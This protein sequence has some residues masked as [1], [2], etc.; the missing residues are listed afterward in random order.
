VR[1]PL[2][3]SGQKGPAILAGGFA[4]LLAFV[5]LWAWLSERQ[6][7]QDTL[8]REAV[9]TQEQ[10][11]SVLSLLQDAETGQRG[12]LITADENYLGPY[13]N[14]IKHLDSNL[15]L[16]SQSLAG[17]AS[18]SKRFEELRPIVGE[19][20]GALQE[21]IT[22]HRQR[23]T[24]E[25]YSLIREGRGQRLMDDIRQRVRDLQ[26]AQDN[27]IAFHTNE[28]EVLREFV[29]WSLLV[30]FFAIMG[31][32][33]YAVADMRKRNANLIVAFEE[34]RR[35]NETLE[36]ALQH[37][38]TAEAQL[39]QA[40][41]MEAVGQ[42]TGG[43]AH[44]FNNMLAVVIGA[45]NLL[46]RRLARG[47]SDVGRF[48]DAALEG[49][50][51]AATL[52]QRL[53]A[54]SRQQPLSPSE[55]DPNRMVAGMADLL[56][57]T[58]G[59]QVRTETVLAAGLWKIHADAGQLESAILNLAV[60]A[61]DAMSEGGKFTI[62]TA[63]AYLDDTYA[64]EH[65]EVPAGQYVLIALSDTGNGMTP[66]II[67]KAFDP[68]FTTKSTGKGTGL[69]L[70]QVYGFVRQ[71]NGHVKIYSEL[72]H[73][74]TI[75]IYLP[76]HFSDKDSAFAAERPSRIAA[77][78]GTANQIILVVE[79]DEGVRRMTVEALRDLGYTVLHAEGAE[80]ALR[81]LDDTPEIALLFTDVV[82]PDVNG[83]KL[84]EEAKRR[85]PDLKVLYTTG[86]TRNAVV[87]NGVLDPGTEFL[88]KPFSIGDLARKI[89]EV[90]SR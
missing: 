3:F 43:I 71:S 50:N 40:Q 17:D 51:R 67:A 11:V 82:M 38:E 44:D 64:L 75:K 19:R 57:L 78:Q 34:L 46:Q 48:I 61:R 30:P 59:E 16:L 70:S 23:N 47:E 7:T 31:L 2:I 60:N 41:K 90:L 88:P 85:R 13:N 53:L 80:I 21:A 6:K 62:E 9:V 84:A 25:A 15:T 86:Y 4:F 79:D 28:S 39:R 36:D 69:G 26:D 68:F 87:H 58:L 35:M 5:L 20:V 52:T 22:F 42:L 10:I 8:A 76:R 27:I 65:M 83:R 73:G 1:L 14:A 66:D 74:T 77:T 89:H 54:F 63:N 12:F 29:R 55:I 81:I 72:E 45:L 24:K 37:R 33:V 32:A 49:A 56:R 18:Q